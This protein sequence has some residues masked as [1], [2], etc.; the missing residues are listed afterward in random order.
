ME[1]V[2]GSGGD[3]VEGTGHG[4]EHGEGGG[5]GQG[6]GGGGELGATAEVEGQGGGNQEVRG[7]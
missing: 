5:D 4:E 6:D 1:D 3:G 7:D 2:V